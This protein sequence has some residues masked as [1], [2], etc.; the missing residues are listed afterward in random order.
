MEDL[1]TKLL[2]DEIFATVDVRN[3]LDLLIEASRSDQDHAHELRHFERE[4]DKYDGIWVYVRAEV[5]RLIC[6]GEKDYAKQR[7]LLR[8][9]SIPALSFISGIIVGHFGVPYATAAALAG[10]ILLVPLKLG[11][12]AWCSHYRASRDAVTREEMRMA[13]DTYS[14]LHRDAR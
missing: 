4:S 5:Y 14:N 6:T 9:S 11:T 3:G 10:A 1:D 12:S 13:F 8:K 7:A 2:A